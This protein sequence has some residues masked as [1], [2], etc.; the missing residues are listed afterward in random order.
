MV[1]LSIAYMFSA[2]GSLDL[3]CY[4]EIGKRAVAH[5]SRGPNIFCPDQET[6]HVRWTFRPPRKGIT[7]VPY[8]EVLSD[9][10]RAWSIPKRSN[11]RQDPGGNSWRFVDKQRVSRR[12][13]PR[14]WRNGLLTLPRGRAAPAPPPPS[15]APAM[16]W[17]TVHKS[18]IAFRAAER[19]PWH[20]AACPRAPT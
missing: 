15:G 2:P 13:P 3:A 7:V 20:V 14:S 16:I 10:V 5:H 17:Q 12:W 18:A 9:P 19:A 6:L 1:F 4:F 11:N 8:V